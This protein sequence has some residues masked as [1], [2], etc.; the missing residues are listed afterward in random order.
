MIVNLYQVCV[1]YS[2]EE[3]RLKHTLQVTKVS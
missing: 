3:Y 1:R 2:R